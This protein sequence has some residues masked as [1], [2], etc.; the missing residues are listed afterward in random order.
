MF[1]IECFFKN[2]VLLR[3]M[4]LLGCVRKVGWDFSLSYFESGQIKQGPSLISEAPC[5]GGAV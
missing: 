1:Y 3:Y 2:V 4:P 5:G